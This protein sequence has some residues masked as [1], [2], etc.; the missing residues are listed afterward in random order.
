MDGDGDHGGGGWEARSAH[1]DRAAAAAQRRRQRW[2]W[3]RRQRPVVNGTSVAP[4]CSG[5]RSSASALR[6][7]HRGAAVEGLVV[8]ISLARSPGSGACGD[9][10]GGHVGGRDEGSSVWH[11]WPRPIRWRVQRG[12][13]L[14]AAGCG[15]T[16]QPPTRRA[17]TDTQSSA[18]VFGVKLRT[19]RAVPHVA[20]H[21]AAAPSADAPPRRVPPKAQPSLPVNEAA[22]GLVEV[23]GDAAVRSP[24]AA[25]PVA[26]EAARSR[27]SA[28]TGTAAAAAAKHRGR[29]TCRFHTAALRIQAALARRTAEA[30]GRRRCTT[31]RRPRPPRNGGGAHISR[32]ASRRIGDAQGE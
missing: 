22:S 20:A 29:W 25:E 14:L 11:G 27:R 26:D 23:D 24:S 31:P 6:A 21:A 10:E 13:A 32:A 12:G 15:Q 7:S 8:V 17:G 16:V 18:N 4:G 30:R 1:V 19:Q 3:Q 5:C 28:A 2:R 9:G